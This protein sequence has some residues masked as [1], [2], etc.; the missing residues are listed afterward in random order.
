MK[1]SQ[2]EQHLAFLKLRKANIKW[3]RENKVK[4]IFWRSQSETGDQL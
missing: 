3:L 1:L 2:K 4:A